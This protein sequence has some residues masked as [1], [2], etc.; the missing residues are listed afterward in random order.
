MGTGAHDATLIGHDDA[1]VGLVAHRDRLF[2]A[3]RDGTIRVWTQG[4]WAPLRTVEVYGG[5]TGLYPSCLV[6]SGSQLVSGS[7]SGLRPEVLVW[8]LETLE[9]QH[10]LPQTFGTIVWALS[11]MESGVWA[12]VGNDV[13]V[14]RSGE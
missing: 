11:S 5:E 8:G 13:V 12:G 1:V 2:S 4:T 9:L 14:W 6:V 7:A 10:R 3:S